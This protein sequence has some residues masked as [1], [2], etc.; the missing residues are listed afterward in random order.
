[1]IKYLNITIFCILFSLPLLSQEKEDK[2]DFSWKQINWGFKGGFNALSSIHYDIWQNDEE[3]TG[4]SYTN[5][6]G[7]SGGLF[8]RINL[9]NIFFQPEVIYNHFQEQLSFQLNEATESIPS[10]I[11]ISAN[12]QNLSF[13]A[14]IGYNIVNDNRYLFNIYLGPD[15]KYRFRS[16]FEHNFTEFL[17]K[18]AHYH[19]N[20]IIG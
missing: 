9:G 6:E 1:M 13:P 5:K 20:G 17:D 15:F 11:K 4:K 7:F 18:K 12:H 16:D 3:I 10:N 14:L 19:I 2:D 8:M